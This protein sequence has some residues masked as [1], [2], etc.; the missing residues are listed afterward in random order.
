MR[1]R[2]LTDEQIQEG[3]RL[4]SDGYTKDK[5]AELFGV[6]STTVWENIYATPRE[7]ALI[8]LRRRRV[9]IPVITYRKIQIV[10][11]AVQ[12]LKDKGLTSNEVAEALHLSLDDVNHLWTK[13]L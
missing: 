8:R 7:R 13:L 12:I 11:Q 1:G 2:V 3:K 9:R 10:L 5:I 4:R 6:G